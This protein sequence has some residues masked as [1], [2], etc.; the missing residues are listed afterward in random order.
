MKNA[1][2]SPAPSGISDGW[3]ADIFD[4]SPWGIIHF[5]ETWT[6]RYANPA[7]SALAGRG[8][9][10]GR[11]L[12]DLLANDAMSAAFARQVRKRE[13]AESSEYEAMITQ[14]DSGRRVPVGI[15]AMPVTRPGQAFGGSVLILR[16]LEVERA[17]KRIDDR[18]ETAE[19][20]EDIFAAVAEEVKRVIP[21]DAIAASRY[22][23]EGE[24]LVMLEKPKFLDKERRWYGLNPESWR[25]LQSFVPECLDLKEFHGTTGLPVL[26]RMI[27]RGYRALMRY[28]TRSGKEVIGA[29][30]LFTKNAAGF[31]KHDLETFSRLPISKAFV[32][33]LYLLRKRDQDVHFELLSA[34]AKS[35]TNENL[36]EEFVN[37][38]RDHYGWSHVSIFTV[39]KIEKQIVL[40]SQAGSFKLKSNHKQDDNIG[41]L[42]LAR[43]D[44]KIVRANDVR[45]PEFKDTVYLADRFPRLRSETCMPIRSGGE[46]YALLNIEDR[47]LHAVSSE[48]QEVLRKLLDNVGGVIERRRKDHV[49]A[50]AFDFTPTPVL[51][52]DMKG[53]I[54][55]P[56]AAATDLLGYADDDSRDLALRGSQFS[57]FV[58]D[59]ALGRVLDTQ[60]DFVG[61]VELRKSNGLP[62]RVHAIASRLETIRDRRMIVLHDLSMAERPLVLEQA[63]KMVSDLAR[64]SSTPLAILGFGLQELKALL[65]ERLSEN[66]KLQTLLRDLTAQ[67]HRVEITYAEMQ[68]YDENSLGR[69]HRERLIPL[70]QFVRD[71]LAENLRLGRRPGRTPLVGRPRRRAQR[72]VSTSVRDPNDRRAPAGNGRLR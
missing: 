8:R 11:T 37:R 13:R 40:Q 29:V 6:V 47:R 16:N 5:D 24:S 45:D 52:V 36:F 64:L 60:S 65:G 30:T 14:A 57:K 43:K 61:K 1:A 53:K 7:A 26:R 54:R 68:L 70:R 4:C 51:I 15:A 20:P 17:A 33:A 2:D 72:S 12:K 32:S 31:T 39:D 58:K 28:P 19:T 46:L 48:E 63:A 69:P 38:L 18:I 55:L 21:F 56:N 71:T 42:G 66:K 50:A 44:N 35:E 9:L 59:P 27:D 22:T 34:I 49:T 41:L 23:R 3:M 62:V 67:L 25:K 10:E